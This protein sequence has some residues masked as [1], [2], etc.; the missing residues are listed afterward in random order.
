MQAAERSMMIISCCFNDAAFKNVWIT[1]PSFSNG[2]SGVAGSL[3]S[4]PASLG[5]CGVHYR[6]CG[7]FCLFVSNT[8]CGVW[9]DYYSSAMRRLKQPASSL[10]QH[11]CKWAFAN[12]KSL[13]DVLMSASWVSRG[14]GGLWERTFMKRFCGAVREQSSHVSMRSIIDASSQMQPMLD[15]L[16]PVFKHFLIC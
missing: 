8:R 11:C 7:F 13:I 16:K 6:C 5:R 10:C 14:I 15:L 12:K 9:R 2:S 3:R 4:S 1:F